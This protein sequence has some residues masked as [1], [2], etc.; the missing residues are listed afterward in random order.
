MEP[1]VARLEEGMREMKAVL[2]WPEPM[3]VRMGEIIATTLPQLATK[4]ELATVRSELKQRGRAQR[5][6]ATDHRTAW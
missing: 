6:A 5:V 1:R 4:A 2:S 3:I